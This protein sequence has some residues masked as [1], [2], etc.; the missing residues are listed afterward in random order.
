MC[1]QVNSLFYEPPPLQKGDLIGVVAPSSRV[2]GY[3]SAVAR[4][5]R[6]LEDSGYRV[7]IHPQCEV[8]LHGSAGTNQEKIQALH[9]VWSDPEIKAILCARGGNRALHV[10]EGLDFDLIRNN[11]KIFM[12]YSDSTALL[13]AITARTRMVSFHGT[14]LIR[15]KDSAF[16]TQ[17]ERI[18]AGAEQHIPLSPAQSIRVGKAR[19]HLVGG[20]LSVFQYLVGTSFLPTCEGALLFLEDCHDETSRFDRMFLHLRRMGVFARIAGLI[21]GEFCGL[22]DTGETPFG[23]SLKAL[24][25]EHTRDYDFPVVYDV[26]FG[27][28]DHLPVFPV[29]RMAHLDTEG[30]LRIEGAQGGHS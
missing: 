2:D 28:G 30:F 5:C 26:P 14:A 23:F 10:L 7:F 4:G 3:A 24:I 6:I 22:Q 8:R 15:I 19:G 20:N 16:W 29:G 18:L 1:A 12:G 9:E 13:C 27:H 21:V 25:E 11:P 17:S